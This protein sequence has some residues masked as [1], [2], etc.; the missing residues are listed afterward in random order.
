MRTGLPLA[1]HEGIASA[2]MVIIGIPKARVFSDGA[3][4]GASK[5]R[6]GAV[7]S[8]RALRDTSQA[9]KRTSANF[10]SSAPVPRARGALS[11]LATV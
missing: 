1:Y 5:R 8:A 7:V 2:P 10:N 9:S 11:L 4:C 6:W 3:Q